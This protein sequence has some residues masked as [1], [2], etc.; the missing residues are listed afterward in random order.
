MFNFFKPSDAYLTTHAAR[1]SEPVF[2]A[3]SIRRVASYLDL[4]PCCDSLVTP[5][6]E[7]KVL[8]TLNRYR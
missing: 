5:E 4:I 7:A 3:D 6:I 2:R 1:I 8:K